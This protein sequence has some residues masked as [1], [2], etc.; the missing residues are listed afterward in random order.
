MPIAKVRETK[1]PEDRVD[2]LLGLLGGS[3]PAIG[4]GIGLESALWHTRATSSKGP[5]LT[6]VGI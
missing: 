6:R 4:Y 2:S 3:L 1:E 5:V